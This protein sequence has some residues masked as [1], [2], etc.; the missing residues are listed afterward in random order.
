MGLAGSLREPDEVI[1]RF[2]AIPESILLR[3]LSA[4]SAL[5]V[6]P[7]GPKYMLYGAEV[8]ALVG[9]VL[10]Q[11]ELIRAQVKNAIDLEAAQEGQLHFV[12][13]GY[14]A[15]YAEAG[16]MLTGERRDYSVRR[17]VFSGIDPQRSVLAGGWGA[18]ELAARYSFTDLLDPVLGGDE[19]RVASVG[20]AWYAD[21]RAKLVL[22][23]LRIE[24]DDREEHEEATA[25]QLRAQLYFTVP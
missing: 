4:S 16:W 14:T 18:F 24:E 19:G 7:E 20:L 5:L 8:A 3:G 2:V 17:G 21:P 25:V 9:P 11:S 12:D 6:G 13:P 22:E 23:G 15:W 10:L 1:V